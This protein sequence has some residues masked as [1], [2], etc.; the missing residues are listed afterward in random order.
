MVAQAALSVIPALPPIPPTKN[1]PYEGEQIT[2]SVRAS[3]QKALDGYSPGNIALIVAAPTGAD[4]KH[5]RSF[6]VTHAQE[7]SRINT[8]DVSVTGNIPITPPA[9]TATAPPPHP[10]TFLPADAPGIPNP[11]VSP[12]ILSKP[13]PLPVPEPAHSPSLGG[14]SSPSSA[15]P[16][17][18]PATLNQAP[19]PIPPVN[20]SAS[21]ASPMVAPDPTD[22][23]TKVPTVT[24][25]VAETGVPKVAGPEGPG[26]S[27]GSLLDKNAPESPRQANPFGSPGAFRVASDASDAH[28]AAAAAAASGPSQFESAEDEK[29][30]LEREEREKILH[31]TTGPSSGTT[32][33]F[34]SAEEEKKRLE[35]EERER[36]LH[37][38]GS[39]ANKPPGDGPSEDLPPYQEF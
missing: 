30:R 29:K 20:T 10:S 26:P 38:G 4:L 11:S 9:T 1:A 25:T 22:P 6:G 36:I 24:P 33:Q 19:A 21:S 18:N 27:S 5:T 15:S 12:S 14:A 13:V 3:L 7:L 35:R 28:A 37:E 31:G 17:L 32:S 8:Q 2:G 23:S 34:E 39:D 16:P